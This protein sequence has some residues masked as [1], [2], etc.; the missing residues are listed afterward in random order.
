VI[1]FRRVSEP[2]KA[3]L[4]T[5]VTYCIQNATMVSSPDLPYD[6]NLSMLF[7]E[8]PL[9]ERPAAA[10]RAGF[11]AIEMWWPFDTATPPD[12]EVDRLV[13][14]IE[15]AGV[16]LILLNFFGGDLAAGDRGLVSWPGRTREFLDG[17]DVAVGIAARTGCRLFNPLYGNRIAGADPGRQDDVALEAL[18]HAAHAAARIDADLVLEPLSNAPRYPLRKAADVVEVI[19][20][21]PRLDNI[22]LLADLYHLVVNGDD[23]TALIDRETGRIGHVQVADAPGRGEPGSG[24][25]DLAGLLGRLIARGYRGH[26]GLEYTPT[27]TTVDSFGWLRAT[28]TTGGARP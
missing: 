20:R 28:E 12:G 26:I 18:A 6:V 23:L 17:V 9:L 13:A 11:D 22:K 25:L 16:R 19:E 27:S 2:I 8:L 24:R 5:A 15:D 1:N 21:L 3:A 10:R 7:T 14:A 4:L